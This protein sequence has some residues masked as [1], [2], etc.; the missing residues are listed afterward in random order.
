MCNDYIRHHLG[1]SKVQGRN[2]EV[3][4]V[5]TT[6]GSSAVFMHACISASLS[7]SLPLS[8]TLA[9]SF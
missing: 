7:L 9:F 2:K 3:T 1:D 6:S 4:I 5:V 8:F